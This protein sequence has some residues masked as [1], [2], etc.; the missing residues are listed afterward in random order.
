M[1]NPSDTAHAPQSATV[2]PP[3]TFI[4]RGTTRLGESAQQPMLVQLG[5]AA[6]TSTWFPQAPPQ[7]PELSQ[8][9]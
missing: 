2:A 6:K 4:I 8:P 1:L 5:C 9:G 7:L 3:V